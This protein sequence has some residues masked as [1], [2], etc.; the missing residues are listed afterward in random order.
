MAVEATISGESLASAPDGYRLRVPARGGLLA[1]ALVLSGATSVW[2]DVSPAAAHFA[3]G[4]GLIAFAR[5]DRQGDREIAVTRPDGSG[6]RMLTKNTATDVDPAWSPSGTHLAF[7]SN[8]SRALNFDIWVMRATGKGQR[9]LTRGPAIDIEPTWSPDGSEIAYASDRAAGDFDVWAVN[10]ETGK[11]RRLTD[12]EGNDGDPDWSPDG[13]RIAYASDRKKGNFDIWVLDVTTGRSRQ[14]TGGLS[15]DFAPAWSP[16]GRAIAFH[17]YPA[18]G[19]SANIRIVR[20]DRPGGREV[21]S[22]KGDELAPSWSPDGKKLVYQ[23]R[24]GC[25]LGC[26]FDLWIA[27][28]REG[29]RRLTRGTARD[30]APDWQ[31]VPADLRLGLAPQPASATVGAEVTYPITVRN[32]GPG[33]ALAVTITL[34]VPETGELVSLT[35]SRGPCQGE[36]TV[37]CTVKQLKPGA[38]AE[39]RAVLRVVGQSEL[40]MT[41]TASSRTFDPNDANSRSDRRT[42]ITGAP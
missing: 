31:P 26:P 4:K 6:L 20:F 1:L 8:R 2:L 33:T 14:L 24:P 39:V 10:V 28:D 41:V 21:T 15:Q 34:I 18:R 16:N 11:K 13:T 36:R 30:I 17:R 29:V 23:S 38:T 5:V 35:A 25:A 32:D 19:G 27:G 40:A 12:S 9:R 7:S 22:R 42:A 3:D 37:V